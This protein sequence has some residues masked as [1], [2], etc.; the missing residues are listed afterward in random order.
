M[1]K[2]KI[3]IMIGT[4]AVLAAVG[5]GAWYAYGRFFGKSGGNSEDKVYVESVA[6]IVQT[7]TGAFNRYSGVVEPQ[8][9]WEVNLDTSRKVLEVYVEEGDEVEEGTP[10]FAYDTSDL[11]LELQQAELEIENI[12]NQITTYNE[13]ITT[14]TRERDKATTDDAKFDYTTQIQTVQTSIRQSQ[15]E[16]ASKKANMDKINTSISES[17]IKS[18]IPG[19]VKKIN[20]AG[21]DDT[22]SS[23]AYMTILATGE[24]QIKGKVN[25]QNIGGISEGQAVI[26]HSRVDDSLTW[27]GTIT[28]ID[29]ESTQTDSDSS[30][31]YY[32]GSA[33]ESMQQSSSYPFY[34]TLDS[35]DGLMLGQHVYIEPDF[36]QQDVKEGL[37]LYGSYLAFDGDTPYVWAADK[38]GRLEKRGVE[39]G[40]YDEDSDEYQIVSGL[41]ASDR[42]AYPMPGLYEGI[43]TVDD[44]SEVDY[45]SPLYTDM[46][47]T[48]SYDM[49]SM[50]GTES[51][52]M[53]GMYGTES[54]DMES[55]YGTEA[56]PYDKYS[57]ESEE[58]QP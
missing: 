56:Y 51:Y 12:N 25:E 18:K 33:G 32:G 5:V 30:M 42:I 2:K 9:T 53:E 20:T 45:N 15:Y 27:K 39:T 38:D 49:E 24:F 52:D 22:G 19:V 6:K 21:T 14:L 34:V 28:K 41:D 10:L 58:V 54:Y 29:T 37:W 36:G 4:V 57:T 8:D 13:Q 17:V 46:Y 31:M 40:D 48:E 44:E 55:I 3:G 16:L 23:G 47:G 50:Y 1:G 43:K 7:S 11:K 35:V 26:V